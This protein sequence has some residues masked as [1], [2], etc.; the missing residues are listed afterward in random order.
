[1]QCSSKL[2]NAF[3]KVGAFSTKRDFICGDP[4]GVV[5]QT[6]GEIDAFDEV[7]TGIVD[8]CA[9]VGVRGAVSLLEKAGYEHAKVVIQTEF[10]LSAN[11]IKEPSAE[12]T[13]LSGKLY[14]E[15]WMNG[16]REIA[17]EAIR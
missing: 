8:F 7:L 9:C 1:M 12:T 10:S 16:G 17:N 2:K 15:V 14:S 13:A 11:D 6:E 5:K 3:A 4:E